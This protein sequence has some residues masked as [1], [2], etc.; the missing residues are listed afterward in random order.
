MKHRESKFREEDHA[1]I[2]SADVVVGEEARKLG[3]VDEIGSVDEVMRQKFGE[4]E[5]KN[6][7]KQSKFAEIIEKFKG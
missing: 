5:L 6:F 4:F 3:L 7:S 1:Q 2:F